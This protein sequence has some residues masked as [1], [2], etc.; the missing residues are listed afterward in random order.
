MQAVLLVV[1]I[2]LLF[3]GAAMEMAEAALKIGFAVLVAIGVL[4]GL[5][6]L[7]LL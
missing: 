5:L 7:S 6:L 2:G 3:V 4:F 1:V